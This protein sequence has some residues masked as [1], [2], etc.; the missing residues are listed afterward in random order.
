M[1][2]GSDKQPETREHVIVNLPGHYHH[3]GGRGLLQ[4]TVITVKDPK[5]WKSL[6]Q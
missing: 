4:V 1:L 6:V 5:T 2:R 3:T